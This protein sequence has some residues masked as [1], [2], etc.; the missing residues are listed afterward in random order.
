MRVFVLASTKNPLMPCHPARARELLKKGKA[1]V[2]R[3]FPFTIILKNRKEGEIQSVELKADPG[4]KTTGLSLVLHG[5]IRKKVVFAA[6]LEHRGSSIKKRL[7]QRRGVRGCRRNRNTRY[8]APRFNNRFRCKGWLPPSLMSR[9]YNVQTWT[10]RLSKFSPISI[11]SVE[12]VRFD[13]Q[14][15]V[16]PEISGTEYQQGE[17]LGYEVREYLLEKWGRKCVYCEKENIPLEVEHIIP[18]SNGGS[19]RISNLTI[20]CRSCNEKKRS[21]DIKTF[22]KKKPE[23]LTKILKTLKVPLKDAAAVNATRYA[24]G[25]A[26]KSI[27][28]PTTFWSGGRTKFNRI[29]Q[30][31]KKDHWIDAACVGESGE[32]I[33][34]PRKGKILLIKAQGHGDR[35]L[36]LVDK[37]GF[38]RSKAAGSRFV[39]GFQTGDFVTAKVTSGKKIGNYKGKVAVRSSGSFNISMKKET[40][41]GI[42]YKYCSKIHSSDGY[43]YSQEEYKC[44][45]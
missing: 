39:Y 29:K 42:S 26:I 5:K 17:L 10:I 33:T 16:N 40:I 44:H 11:C 7:E 1:A 35:Q 14:K 24:I 45:A 43:H 27:G 2:F 22:L 30:G 20:S 6:N 12:T 36:C 18:K 21:Q 31:Y 25:S 15:M 38:P 4:S 37:Y 19:N 32:K 34:I 23:L 28:L 9:V 13:M 8:R 3:M 41:Q